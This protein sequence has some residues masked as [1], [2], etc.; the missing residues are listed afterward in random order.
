MAT[1]PQDIVSEMDTDKIECFACRGLGVLSKTE[2]LRI[3]GGKDILKMLKMNQEEFYSNLN[4]YGAVFIQEVRQ[5]LDKKHEEQL[6]T[7]RDYLI[8]TLFKCRIYYKADQ[9]NNYQSSIY[10]IVIHT[11]FRKCI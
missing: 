11:I 1:E 9:K 10:R 8:Y 3:I 4:S 5:A 2:V 6:R 7:V